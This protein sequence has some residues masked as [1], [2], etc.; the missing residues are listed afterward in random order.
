MIKKNNIKID[1]VDIRIKLHKD[2]KKINLELLNL[3]SDVLYSEI[4]DL[5]KEEL[6]YLIYPW[7]NFYIYN[8]FEIY[9]KLQYQNI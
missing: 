6:K 7:L 2:F 8:F 3:L 9:N 4:S 5:P 1:D